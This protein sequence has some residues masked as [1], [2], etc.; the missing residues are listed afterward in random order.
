MIRNNQSIFDES[1]GRRSWGDQEEKEF[2][3]I[4]RRLQLAAGKGRTLKKK[5]P[6][7][8]QQMKMNENGFKGKNLSYFKVKKR[9]TNR[10]KSQQ[11]KTS[12]NNKSVGFTTV[13]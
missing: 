13:G 10:I 11:S 7:N 9:K 5:R 8:K 2:N 4:G 12:L 6:I 1:C 3:I